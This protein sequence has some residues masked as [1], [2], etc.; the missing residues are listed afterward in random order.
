MESVTYPSDDSCCYVFVY[1][2]REL[3]PFVFSPPIGNVYISSC[4]DKLQQ[5]LFDLLLSISPIAVLS[6][7]LYDT[8]IHFLLNGLCFLS[9]S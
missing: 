8:D 4:T 7:I 5:T 2:A 6:Q 1:A 9:S 3:F